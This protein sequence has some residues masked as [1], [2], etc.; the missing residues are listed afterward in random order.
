MLKKKKKLLLHFIL[1]I[2]HINWMQPHTHYTVITG[3]ARLSHICTF[4][5]HDLT[6]LY[7]M[8]HFL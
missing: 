4:T 8:C 6:D 5:H 1:I 3:V 7:H 2:L